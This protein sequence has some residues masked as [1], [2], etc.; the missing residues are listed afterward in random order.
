MNKKILSILGLI[1]IGVVGRLLP[2]VPNATPITAVTVTARK[3][4]GRTW[5]FVIP[6]VAMAA[7]D[8]FI[9]FYDWRVMASVYVSFILIAAMSSLVKKTAT[10]LAI[11]VLAALSSVLFFLVTNF[12]VWAFSPLYAKSIWGLLE[13]YS[14]GLVFFR[15]ML[16]GD[17]LY[18]TLIVGAFELARASVRLPKL[19]A[20]PEQLT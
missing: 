10:P 5:A 17:V 20:A 12:A 7:S 6:L 1:G 2:H 9:G 8:I 3:Y 14:A 15:S 4:I 19:Q 18:T 11:I 16:F 13:C